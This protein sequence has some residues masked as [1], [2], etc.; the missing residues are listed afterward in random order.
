MTLTLRHSLILIAFLLTCACGGWGSNDSYDDTLQQAERLVDTNPDSTLLI[1]DSIDINGIADLETRAK[2]FYIN[3]SAKFNLQNFPDAMWSLLHA[4]KIAGESND[5]RMLATIRRKMMELCDSIYDR[6][7][8]SR[9][10]LSACEAYERLGDYD[11]VY[12][13]VAEL[14]D[15]I[16]RDP[17]SVDQ[18]RRVTGTLVRH[19]SELS[20]TNNISRA[21]RI[22]RIANIDRKYSLIDRLQYTGLRSHKFVQIFN[23]G[24]AWENAILCDSIILSI[25]DL[26]AIT[27]DLWQHNDDRKAQQLITCFIHNYGSDGTVFYVCNHK[28]LHPTRPQPMVSG[29]TAR[30]HIMES[31]QNET[32]QVITKFNYEENLL[33]AQTISYQRTLLLLTLLVISLLVIAI[34]LTL[35]LSRSRRLR[36]E[37]ENMRTAM[38]LQSAISDSRNR[39]IDTLIHL[40][41]TYYEG[42]NKESVKSKAAKEAL[43]AIEAFA[44]SPEFFAQLEERLNHRHKGLMDDFRAQ[45]PGLKEAD[46][47]LFLCNSLELSIPAICLLLKG[48][49]ELIYNRRLRL[50]GK[51][52]TSDAPDKERFLEYLK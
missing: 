19:K 41:N 2:A 15:P 46:Y 47:R 12:E 35:R 13:L 34:I 25:N 51:I 26:H 31:F 32:Y 27:N 5:M 29:L 7:G 22:D 37:E 33:K 44:D 21:E 40:C 20:D 8:M 48:K 11:S 30:R 39:G 50:R 9:Y 16:E 17:E 10:G 52:Q 23:S 4:E 49:R 36:K 45:M 43:S 3:G 1:I 42:F 6:K 14:V 24:G 18:L 38:E 28:H